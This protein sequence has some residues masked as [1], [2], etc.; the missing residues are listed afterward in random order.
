MYPAVGQGAIGIECRADD[1]PVQNALS[2]L[3]DSTAWLET[4]AERSLMSGVGAG[5]HAPLGTIAQVD[6]ERLSL[7]AVV[8]SPDGTRKWSALATRAKSQAMELGRIVAEELL[9]LGAGAV[10]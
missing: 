1:E 4:T 6:G 10:L 7:N 3:N 5:C 9:Q 8:L 2:C